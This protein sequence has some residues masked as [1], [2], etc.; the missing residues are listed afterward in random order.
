[1]CCQEKSM[2]ISLS[3]Y[4]V[5]LLLFIGTF[6]G[7]PLESSAQKVVLSEI[8]G[9]TERYIYKGYKIMYKLEGRPLTYARLKRIEND[10]LITNTDSFKLSDISFIG[11][12]PPITDLVQLGAKIWYYTSYATL[13]VAFFAYTR[14]PDIPEI[15][16]VLA[17]MG[18]VPLI[19]SRRIYSRSEF[20]VFDLNF[21]WEAQIR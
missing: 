10:M 11:Y 12:K 3:R 4:L 9:N 15:G 2:E 5:L 1:M 8:D 18:F 13:A 14:L 17:V 7:F 19:I 6:L 21:K 20:K 16:D